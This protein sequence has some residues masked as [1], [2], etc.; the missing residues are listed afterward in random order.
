MMFSKDLLSF[1][2]AVVTNL[3]LKNTST[4]TFVLVIIVL[5][6]VNILGRHCF[7]LRLVNCIFIPDLLQGFK[8]CSKTAGLHFM[9]C[10][11]TY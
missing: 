11:V 6:T 8:I 1:I 9:Y 4:I 2:L 3:K 10:L 5:K 7:F